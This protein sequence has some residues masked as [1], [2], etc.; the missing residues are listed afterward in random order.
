MEKCMQQEFQVVDIDDGSI[1]LSQSYRH[2]KNVTASEEQCGGW[3]SD[4]QGMLRLGSE[5]CLP[6][7]K[8]IETTN[9]EEGRTCLSDKMCQ[10]L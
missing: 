5:I 9:R 4:L 1:C 6:L 8:T 2:C 7:G 3:C 10:S